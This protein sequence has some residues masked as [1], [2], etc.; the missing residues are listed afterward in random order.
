LAAPAYLSTRIAV[1]ARSWDVGQY[2]LLQRDYQKWMD[3]DN[4]G[5]NIQ[6]RNYQA[7]LVF[8]KGRRTSRSVE[9]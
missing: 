5:N 7:M 3:Y 2:R 8:L 9:K 1:A 4:S 6:G